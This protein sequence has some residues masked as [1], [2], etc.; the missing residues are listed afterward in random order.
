LSSEAVSHSRRGD[1][2]VEVRGEEVGDEHAVHRVA[3]LGILGRI[4]DL[5]KTRPGP[6]RAWWTGPPPDELLLVQQVPGRRKGSALL[7]HHDDLPELT[8]QLDASVRL[9][10]GR[11]HQAGEDAYLEQIGTASPLTARDRVSLHHRP[12]LGNDSTAASSSDRGRI[13]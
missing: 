9:V 11:E 5:D 2:I 6:D 3:E 7:H 10:V 12:A 8:R 1:R 13:A 4:G